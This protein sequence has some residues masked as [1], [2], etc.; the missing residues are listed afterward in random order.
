MRFIQLHAWDVH[1]PDHLLV[2]RLSTLG[3]HPL[4]AIHGLEIDLTDVGGPFVTDAP[5]LTLEQ[6]L[7]FV[8]GQLAAG[9]QCPFSLRELVITRGAAQPFDVLV[10]TCPGTMNNRVDV[11]AIELHTIWIGA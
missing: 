8:F 5:A 2:M 3:R 10:F 4:K 9:H 1:V 6:P 11:G 7:H